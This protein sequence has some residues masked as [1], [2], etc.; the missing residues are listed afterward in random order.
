MEKILKIQV[1]RI[2]GYS[3]IS[4][5]IASNNWRNC[6]NQSDPIFKFKSSGKA[7]ELGRVIAKE[8]QVEFS[9]ISR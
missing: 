2:K 4:K 8:L 1:E 7:F 5:I 9:D 6:T 3:C